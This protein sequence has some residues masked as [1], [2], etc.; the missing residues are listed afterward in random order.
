MDTK[1]FL[2][3]GRATGKST[4]GKLIAERLQIDFV[5][6]DKLVEKRAGQTIREIVE[7]GGWQAFRQ[8]EHALLAELCGTNDL[9]VATGGGAVVHQ[10]L[11][12][13]IKNKSLVV[14]LKADSNTIRTRLT[15]DIKSQSQRPS[16]TG[17][18]IIA[19][20]S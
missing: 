14:W 9:I 8:Q 13:Q 10:D 18:D 2:I 5:D 15:H 20:S 4:L 16:L 11:W 12:P 1:I 19:E 6:M 3:G 7:Q 17:D